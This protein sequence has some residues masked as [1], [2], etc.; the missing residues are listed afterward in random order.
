[1]KLLLI[2]LLGDDK[3]SLIFAHIMVTTTNPNVDPIYVGFG[4]ILI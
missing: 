1:M 4:D 3:A 2:E